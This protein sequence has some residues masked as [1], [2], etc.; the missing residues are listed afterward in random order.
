MD[1]CPRKALIHSLG[2]ALA[3][4]G[5][6]ASLWEERDQL[7]CMAGHTLVTEVGQD[8]RP[9]VCQEQSQGQICALERPVSPHPSAFSGQRC[10]HQESQTESWNVHSTR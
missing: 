5:S 3:P 4:G 7:L 2:A 9:L 8:R 1:L 6:P 10:P